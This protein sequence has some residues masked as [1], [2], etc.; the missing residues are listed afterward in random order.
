MSLFDFDF[1]SRYPA[2]PGFKEPDT[3]RKAAASMAPTASLLRGQCLAALRE[4]GPLT[5]DECAA[6]LER[7]VLAIRPRFTEMLERGQI[8]D[9]GERR[10][11][12]S[13]RNAK[14]WRIA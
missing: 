4:Y 7:T 9:S 14:V 3:S 1:S 10:K 13:N 8:V 6:I 2:S 12:A 5:A 11:N